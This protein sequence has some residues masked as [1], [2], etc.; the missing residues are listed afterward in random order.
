MENISKNKLAYDILETFRANLKNT[1]EIDIR[2]IK[3]WVD[4]T[5]ATLLKRHFDKYFYMPIDENL[6]QA[7]APGG[8]AI[9]MEIVDSS[10]TTVLPTGRYYIRS[11]V[12][13]SATIERNGGLPTFTRIGPADKLSERFQVVNYDWGL[14]Y[15]NGKFNHDAVCAFMLGDRLVLSSKNKQSVFGIKYVDVRGVFQNPT[16]VA[17]LNNPLST[18]DMAY[19]INAQIITEMKDIILN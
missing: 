6:V 19:P 16:E 7:Y 14:L 8:T 9:T 5:R 3:W 13:I 10:A 15:G 4:T 11:T 2:S 1:D 12:A 17:L 18:D